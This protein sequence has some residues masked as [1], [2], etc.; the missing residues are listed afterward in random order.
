M[1]SNIILVII[2]NIIINLIC[3]PIYIVIIWP[4]QVNH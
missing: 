4:G 3:R 1:K 2:G